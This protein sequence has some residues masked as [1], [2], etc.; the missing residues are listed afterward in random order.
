MAA[1][2]RIKWQRFR[3]G[4]CRYGGATGHPSAA[5][6]F[7]SATI[8]FS[9]SAVPRGS[10]RIILAARLANTHEVNRVI[11][12]LEATPSI[13]G[14]PQ[15]IELVVLDVDHSIAPSTNQVVMLVDLPVKTGARAGVVQSANKTQTHERVQNAI[16]G[17]ARESWNAVL[18]GL[19][20]LVRGGVVVSLQDGLQDIS[21][22][23]RERQSSLATKGLESLQPLLDLSRV[24]DRQITKLPNW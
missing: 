2:Q 24:H 4:T 10:R 15:I 14:Q 20:Y 8:F 6:T 16:H 21:A 3:Q 22:L 23:H 19:V 9:I 1:F 12:D 5:A 7:S 11:F 17:C 18:D 13:G